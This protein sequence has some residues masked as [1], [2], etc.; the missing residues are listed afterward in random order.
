MATYV[1][2]VQEAQEAQV[3]DLGNLYP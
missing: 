3:Y 2:R 1:L